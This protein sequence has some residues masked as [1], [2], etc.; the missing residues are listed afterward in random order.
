MVCAGWMKS[1]AYDPVVLLKLIGVM[2]NET[3][4]SQVLETI[5][6]EAR[7][8]DS[9]LLAE[10]SDPEIRAYRTRI[11]TA[12]VPLQG[13]KESQQFEIENLFFLR[14]R[15]SNVLESANLSSAQKDVITS[16]LLP[17]IPT[18]C[19]VFEQ[20]TQQLIAAAQASDEELQDVQSFI[21]LQLLKLAEL[22]NLHEEG[23]R[24]HF[25]FVMKEMLSFVGTPDE[26]VEGCFNALRKACDSETEMIDS[27][28][29]VIG[30]LQNA[31]YE[32]EEVHDENDTTDM[33]TVCLVR[34]LSILTV[35]L[36]TATSRLSSDAAV[37][38]FAQ[39]IVPSVSHT[40]SFVR[41]AAVSCF[42]KLGL[43]TDEHTIT[44]EFKPIL[45]QV[46]SCDEEKLEIRAQAL[47]ALADWSM[48]FSDC[49][50]PSTV[51][52]TEI[53]FPQVVRRFMDD[54]RSAAVCISA[55]VAAK[56]LFSGRVCDSDWFAKLL[57]IFF[58]PRME[59]MAK[60]ND[61]DFKEVGSPIRLQQLLTLFFPAIC[62]QTESTGRDAM[63]GSI[64]HMLELVYTKQ[65]SA[66]SKGKNSRKRVTWPTLKMLQYVCSVID[67]G[68][69]SE[70][71]STVAAGE[72]ESNNADEQMDGST[73]AEEVDVAAVALNSTSLL[74]GV[75]VADF[76]SKNSHNLTDAEARVLCKFLGTVDFDPEDEDIENLASLKGS[77]EELGML[78]TDTTSLKYIAPLNELVVDVQVEEA[79]EEE[80]IDSD[81]EGDENEDDKDEEDY[82]EEKAEG[83]IYLN[84]ELLEALEGCKISDGGIEEKE[85][86]RLANRPASSNRKLSTENTTSRTSRPRLSDITDNQ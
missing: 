51:D 34:I 2:D 61:A 26:I 37:Q 71:D 18:L 74:A 23:S 72:G 12:A 49:L 73:N 69:T 56:L 29:D 42:G 50:A 13:L 30:S 25:A 10:L 48:L 68:K 60:D 53:S 54:S 40:D 78:L 6:E 46:A 8:S 16:K 67:S 85:N 76:L 81:E 38:E 5:M 17:E 15:C 35:V 52:D 77:L 39:Y 62:M 82:G 70:D 31:Q 21:C 80:S 3:E 57:T 4:A 58:D 9:E 44:T 11:D 45:L 24:R 55:E 63:M 75:Q 32:K 84:D 22:S 43:F 36:E 27:V 66:S 33:E 79:E 59:E 47:L 20:H 7:A 1:V 65:P 28:R 64:F 83:Q 14:V 19:E 86:S 41:E